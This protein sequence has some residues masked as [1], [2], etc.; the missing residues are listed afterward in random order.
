MFFPVKKPVAHFVGDIRRTRKFAWW[1]VRIEAYGRYRGMVWLE[2]YDCV[3]ECVQTD[4][5]VPLWKEIGTFYP[6]DYV[7]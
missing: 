3:E 2:H 7:D 1:P 5:P 6:S 4:T